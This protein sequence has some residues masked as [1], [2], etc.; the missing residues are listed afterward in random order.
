MLKVVGEGKFLL[1]CFS[2]VHAIM[3]TD[4]DRNATG[5]LWQSIILYRV[6]SNHALASAPITQTERQRIFE[7][8]RTNLQEKLKETGKAV[9]PVIAIVLILCL[10]I[11][12]FHRELMAFHRGS[13]AYRGNG[14][15]YYGVDMAMT[16]MGKRVGTCMTQSRKLWAACP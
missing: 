16:P 10:S 2:P 1:S 5:Q 7:V 12:R 15:V 9:F 13:A 4:H 8:F 14:T 6:T 11:A 3:K